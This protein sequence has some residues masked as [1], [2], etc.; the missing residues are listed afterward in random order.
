MKFVQRLEANLQ[1]MDSCLAARDHEKL[2]A[3]GHWLK[4]SA[5]MV[6]FDAF[7][8]ATSSLAELAR[9]QKWSEIEAT[10]EELRSLADR[11]EIPAVDS[12]GVIANREVAA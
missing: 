2:A 9:E 4:G 5:G 7:G 6:G 12:S 10:L 3:F 8:G 11:I 1:E